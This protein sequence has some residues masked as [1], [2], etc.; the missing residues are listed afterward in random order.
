ML[1]SLKFHIGFGSKIFVFELGFEYCSFTK[2]EMFTNYKLQ[3]NAEH[4]TSTNERH[5]HT[6]AQSRLCEYIT[7]NVITIKWVNGT[8]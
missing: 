8:Q 4:R 6:Y 7:M 2:Y 1:H 5:S 3:L